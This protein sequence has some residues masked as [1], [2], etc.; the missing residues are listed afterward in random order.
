MTKKEKRT[1]NFFDDEANRLEL[2]FRYCDELDTK[3]NDDNMWGGYA[4]I[5]AISL[6]YKTP[7]FIIRVDDPG[8][9]FP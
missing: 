5:V 3:G 4:E 6:C 7:I 2:F 1:R 8:W 9:K